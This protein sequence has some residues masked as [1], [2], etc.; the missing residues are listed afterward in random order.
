MITSCKKAFGFSIVDTEK[1]EKQYK[2]S[3]SE[4]FKSMVEKL[5]ISNKSILFRNVFFAV[6]LGSV[7]GFGFFAYAI[8]NHIS[9]LVL[10][11]LLVK[12]IFFIINQATIYSVF[13]KHEYCYLG[14]TLVSGITSLALITIFILIRQ[15]D[16]SSL[17]QACL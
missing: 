15:S 12:T 9:A 7:L 3:Q 11:I 10:Y 5:D 4:E 8:Y 1:L 14:M 16:R 13:H 17:L 6:S 2:H